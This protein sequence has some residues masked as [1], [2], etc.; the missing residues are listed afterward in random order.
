MEEKKTMEKKTIKT[1]TVKM[2]AG[3]LVVVCLGWTLQAQAF[4]TDDGEGVGAIEQLSLATVGTDTVED[5]AVPVPEAGISFW[6]MIVGAAIKGGDEKVFGESSLPQKILDKLF[7]MPGKFGAGLGIAKRELV[8]DREGVRHRLTIHGRKRNGVFSPER[9]FLSRYERNPVRETC[10]FEAGLENG[11]LYSATCVSFVDDT[12]V[13]DNF[14]IGRE[15]TQ[16][17]FESEL[18]FWLEK[19]GLTKPAKRK[20]RDLISEETRIKLLKHKE[21]VL[22]HLDD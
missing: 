17:F 16:R 6:K 10:S 7:G 4:W 12:L 20:L 14:D 2:F 3:L 15:E 8:D 1:N 21:R 13:T 5:M 9:V 18:N 22:R 19:L 11:Q